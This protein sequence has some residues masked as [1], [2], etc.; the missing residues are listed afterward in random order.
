MR[1]QN[2][3]HGKEEVKEALIQSAATLFSEKGVEAV[4]LRMI[5]DH[6]GVNHGLIHRH[7]GSKEMLRKETQER[8]S[9]DVRSEIGEP[10]DLV[11]IL[12]RALR[13]IREHDKF[14]RV[15]ART[16]LDDKNHGEI[17]SDF[18]FV[19]KL[20][21]RVESE[22]KADRITSDVDAKSIVASFLAYG[23]GMM[24]FKG[25]IL[26]AVNLDKDSSDDVIEKLNLQLLSLFTK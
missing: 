18:P 25:Y 14:W 1:K 10:D 7:F 9:A 8:L 3:P 19:K 5:A 12:F 2:R 16:L 20:V 13:V 23:L 6:A 26:P 15:M 4:S 24:V 21:E 11:E 17:Q 22:Q